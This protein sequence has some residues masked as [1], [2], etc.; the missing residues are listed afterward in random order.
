M[1]CVLIVNTRLKANVKLWIVDV[2]LSVRLSIYCKNM[3]NIYSSVI[4]TSNASHYQSYK[5][6]LHQKKFRYYSALR[7]I[8]GGENTF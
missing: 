2:N 4:I 1:Q 6:K 8:K 7:K 3:V 5:L